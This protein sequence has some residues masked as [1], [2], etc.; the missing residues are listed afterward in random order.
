M[1]DLV[2]EK[3]VYIYRKIKQRGM[4]NGIPFKVAI[5]TVLYIACREME[6]PQTLRELAEISNTDV[7][8]ASKFYRTVLF[9]LDLK[10]PQI[11]PY[12]MISKILNICDT[13]EKTK[14]FAITLM[15]NIKN[16][17]LY[18][19]KDPTGLAGAIVYMACKRNGEHIIQ[20]QIANATGVT[21]VTIRNNLRFLE[22][23]L[24]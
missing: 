5:T 9:E 8:K 18:I 3:A 15:N 19:G 6:I 4:T 7:K 17:K 20:Y 10:V 2:I 22:E 21:I 24:K 12:K 14:I 16:K 1:S 23:S 11:D 13:S